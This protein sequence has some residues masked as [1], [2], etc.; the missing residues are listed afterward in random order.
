LMIDLCGGKEKAR[1]FYDSWSQ[2]N[3]F[4]FL[5]EKIRGVKEIISGKMLKDYDKVTI[6]AR[7]S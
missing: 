7:K 4:R 3:W 6:I 1:L 5:V 2:K